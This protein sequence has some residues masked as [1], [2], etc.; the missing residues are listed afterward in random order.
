[1]SGHRVARRSLLLGLAGGGALALAACSSEPQQESTPA[2]S[3]SAPASS[4]AG[5]TTPAPSS[6]SPT[7]TPTSAIPAEPVEIGEVVEQVT[8]LTSPWGMA[9]LADGRLLVSERDTALIKVVDGDQVSELAEVPGVRHGGE[10]GLL[11]LA[12]RPGGQE[13]FVHHTA[14]S[15]N[16]VVAASWDGQTLG[17]FRDVLTGMPRATIH[18]G[19]QLLFGSADELYVSAGDGNERP[20]AQQEDS[21][22][23][24][25]LR[26]TPDGQ[27]VEG[28]PFG[29]EVFSMGHRNVQGLALDHE[30]RLWA[31]EFGDKYQDE[32]NLIEAGNNY[33]WPDAEGDEGNDGFTAPQVSWPTSQA[34]PSGLAYAAGSLWMSGLRGERLWQ[35]LMTPDGGLGEPKAWFEGEY[36]RLRAVVAIDE[37]TLLVGTSNTDGRGD[38]RDGDDRLLRLTLG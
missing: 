28:N 24:K 6:P 31:S 38:I 36:G 2:P 30:G 37:T 20:T 14:S 18:N 4:G 35:I 3:G 26:I 12:L 19:G 13:L 1:M 16:R 21:L 22:A 5:P 29:N 33:G 8:G 11:G 23:G 34:S 15:D 17:E 10:G 25:I 27:P 9:L 7:P 32:L